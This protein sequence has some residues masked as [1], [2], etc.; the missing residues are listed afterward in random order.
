MKLNF[1]ENRDFWAHFVAIAIFDCQFWR[2]LGRLWRLVRL[3]WL[4][5][6]VRLLRLV[7]FGIACCSAPRANSVAMQG[8]HVL[9]P[10]FVGYRPIVGDDTGSATGN[11]VLKRVDQDA[12]AATTLRERGWPPPRPWAWPPG[13]RPDR[14]L[15]RRARP[16]TGMGAGEDG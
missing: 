9:V 4:L 13:G 7:C 1:V 6:L 3:L 14:G 10:R 16:T 12:S 8:V 11:G 2:R 15:A 5:R